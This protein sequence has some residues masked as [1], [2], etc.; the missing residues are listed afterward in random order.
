MSEARIY[1]DIILLCPC[2]GLI[3]CFTLLLIFSQ[4]KPDYYINVDLN[5][6]QVGKVFSIIISLDKF[7]VCQP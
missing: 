4:L 3:L 2:R 5:F 6:C 1:Q 7:L